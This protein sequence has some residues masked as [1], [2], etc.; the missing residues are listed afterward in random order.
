MP[1]TIAYD[2]TNRRLLIGRGYVDNVAPQVSNYVSGKQVLQHWF[3][4][5]KANRQ[6]PIIGNR[7]PPSP[8]G[9]V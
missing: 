5:R 8:L 1:D 4:Y 3:S 2:A 9:D 6:R 7:P